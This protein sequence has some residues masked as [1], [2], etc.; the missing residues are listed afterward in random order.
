MP[1]ISRS[2]L[3]FLAGVFS[4]FGQT[5]SK[6]LRLYVIDMEGGHASLFVTPSGQSLLIDAANAGGR[7]TGRIMEA[8]ADA[9]SKQIDYLESRTHYRPEADSQ[10]IARL[11]KRP[12]I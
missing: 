10:R 8:I 7:D 3:M 12:N 11:V 4:T 2:S 5:R 9:G 1:K 6:E